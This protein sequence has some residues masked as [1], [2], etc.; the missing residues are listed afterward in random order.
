MISTVEEGVL[1][2]KDIG[3]ISSWRVI[4]W[5]YLLSN[6]NIGKSLSIINF[7]DHVWNYFSFSHTH[8]Y[9]YIYIYFRFEVCYICRNGNK[10]T[11]LLA[12]HA[13][14]VEHYFTGEAFGHKPNPYFTWTEVHLYFLEHALSNDVFSF[15]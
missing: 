12:R 1:F 10:S 11:N 9:I 7:F 13:Q 8:T 15:Y 4:P 2:A 14:G 5:W 6:A 3:T